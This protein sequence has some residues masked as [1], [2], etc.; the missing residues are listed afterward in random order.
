MRCKHFVLEDAIDFFILAADVDDL[1]APDSRD[2]T[3]REYSSRKECIEL[4]R[5]ARDYAK[6]LCI[7]V[8]H[9][10]A[11]EEILDPDSDKKLRNYRREDLD[12]ASV[13]WAI[14]NFGYYIKSNF[15]ADRL[16]KT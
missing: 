16:R 15:V 7:C 3:L 10:K 1:I 2:P 13:G 5:A 14:I 4:M 12:L 9:R 8:D 11:F 6:H